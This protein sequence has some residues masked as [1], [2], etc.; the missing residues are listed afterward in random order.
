MTHS[1]LHTITII[2]QFSTVTH[3]T[4]WQH[5]GYQTVLSV[6][7]TF[8]NYENDEVIYMDILLCVPYFV[9]HKDSS[10]I[11][12]KEDLSDLSNTTACMQMCL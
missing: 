7:M 5:V 3:L 10:V 4:S 6:N 2:S 11:S 1:Q 8:L 12:R 9:I